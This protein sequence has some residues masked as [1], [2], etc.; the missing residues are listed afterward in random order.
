LSEN[1]GAK[2]WLYVLTEFQNCCVKDIL[3]ACFD[4][5]EELLINQI[6]RFFSISKHQI[7]L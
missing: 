3:I 2:F 6:C 5:F 1:E 4:C 7:Q